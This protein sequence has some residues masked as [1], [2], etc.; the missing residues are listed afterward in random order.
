MN[1]EMLVILLQKR[2]WPT[3]QILFCSKIE[4]GMLATSLKRKEKVS[5]FIL[6]ELV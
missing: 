5:I 2:I 3:F 6:K 1:S 4:F